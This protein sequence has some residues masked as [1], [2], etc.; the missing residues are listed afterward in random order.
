MSE[1]PQTHTNARP[2]LDIGQIRVTALLDGERDIDNMANAFP[3]APLEQS[4]TFRDRYPGVFGADDTWHLIIRAWLIRAAGA[5]ILVDTGIGG[6]TAPGPEW[7]GSTGKLIDE[8]AAEGIAPADV[9]TVVITHIHDDHL[10]GTVDADGKPAF[11]DAR[12]VIHAADL[13]WQRDLATKHDDDRAY[14]DTLLQPLSDAG[15]LDEAEGS[16][17]IAAG[18]RTEHVPGHTPGHQVVRATSDGRQLLITGDAFTHPMQL[19]HPEWTNASDDDP[20]TAEASRRELLAGSAS[21][22]DLL[23]APTHFEQPFG[24]IVADPEGVASWRAI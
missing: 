5:L 23:L 4:L 15:L 19:A 9:D 20:M 24:R 18:V 8:L 14:W 2:S 13:A 1:E 16:V 10:G 3:G 17:D 12:Y 6:E 11:P 21:G 22:P 7:F